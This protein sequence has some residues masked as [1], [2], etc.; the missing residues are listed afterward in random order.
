MAI[1]IGTSVF[2]TGHHNPKNLMHQKKK[3]KNTKIDTISMI[4]FVQDA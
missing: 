2:P 3:K 1:A 4:G